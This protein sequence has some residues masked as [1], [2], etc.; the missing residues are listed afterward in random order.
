MTLFGGWLLTK[1]M[2]RQQVTLV[3]TYDP[4]EYD[5]PEYWDWTELSGS[6][7]RVISSES[8]NL[9]IVEKDSDF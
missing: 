8:P 7:C 5:H 9:V 4:D 2:F 6:Y 1:S 3:V